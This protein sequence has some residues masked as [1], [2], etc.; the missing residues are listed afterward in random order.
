MAVRGEPEPVSKGV[1]APAPAAS[2]PSLRSSPSGKKLEEKKEEKPP[3]NHNF[4]RTSSEKASLKKS[5]A[6]SGGPL[7]SSG[8]GLKPSKSS[9]EKEFK[10][11]MEDKTRQLIDEVAKEKEKIY[12]DEEKQ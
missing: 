11:K 12:Q 2:K 9:G 6:P 1:E 8:P 4:N 10:R 7:K 5:P 3:V